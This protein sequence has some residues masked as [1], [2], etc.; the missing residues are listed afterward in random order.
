MGVM[1]CMQVPDVQHDGF[2]LTTYV[3]FCYKEPHPHVM[4]V[5]V[6]DEQAIKEAM[7]GGDIH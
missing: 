6:D 5:V 4:C 2:Q 1:A 7:W 3:V